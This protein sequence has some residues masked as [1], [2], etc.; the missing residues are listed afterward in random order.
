[1]VVS[2]TTGGGGGPEGGTSVTTMPSSLG[3][4]AKEVRVDDRLATRRN[5]NERMFGGCYFSAKNEVQ[6][7]E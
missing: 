1:M 3:D 2:I 4:C 6:S 7:G 5:G